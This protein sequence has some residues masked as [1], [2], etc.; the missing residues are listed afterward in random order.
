MAFLQ[1]CW[2]PFRPKTFALVCIAGLA[3]GSAGANA[4]D[5]FAGRVRTT[6]FM[7]PILPWVPF[8]RSSPSALLPGSI[9]SAV[10]RRL[11][12]STETLDLTHA[13]I[14][15]FPDFPYRK[16][17]RTAGFSQTFLAAKNAY[18]LQLL[19]GLSADIVAALHSV[20]TTVRN[21]RYISVAYDEL[22]GIA[23]KALLQPNC[24]ARDGATVARP[25]IADIDI[26]IQANSL[27][28][29]AVL[30]R[31]RSQFGTVAPGKQSFAP[32]TSDVR[33]ADRLIA[34]TLK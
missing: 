6:Y 25:L 19:L 27:D 24:S 2:L 12:G 34:V 20:K 15:S 26:D 1:M 30:E 28:V 29:K 31:L 16:P 3:A 32:G 9:I 21:A 22:E 13:R 18:E 5:S 23:E 4:Q 10:G 11:V 8:E 17:T 33:L 14:C 7:Q